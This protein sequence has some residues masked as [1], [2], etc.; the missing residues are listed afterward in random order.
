LILKLS[1]SQN[2]IASWRGKKL[3]LRAIHFDSSQFIG[4]INGKEAKY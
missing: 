2:P 4:T 3:K 1:N